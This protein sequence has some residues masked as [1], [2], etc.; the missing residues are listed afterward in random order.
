[1][2][3]VSLWAASFLC[4]RVCAVV[5]SSVWAA[6]VKH[7]HFAAF[8]LLLGLWAAAFASVALASIY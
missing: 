8:V 4:G 6:S 5:D 3:V 2:G 7:L 1:M